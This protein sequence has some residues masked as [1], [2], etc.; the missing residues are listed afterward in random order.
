MANQ[1]DSESFFSELSPGPRAEPNRPVKPRKTGF[2]WRQVIAIDNSQIL[3]ENGEVFPYSELPKLLQTQPSSILVANHFGPIMQFLIREFADNDLWQFRASPIERD[4]YQPNRAGRKAVMKD[5]VIGYLGFRG[6]NKQKGHYHFPLSPQTFVLKGIS[7]LR[8]NAP[9]E[10]STISKLMGWGKEVRDFLQANDL[11]LSPTSGGIAAQFLKDKRFYPNDRRKVPRHTNAKARNHLPGNYYKLYA[12]EG[13]VYRN[14]KAIY[15]AAYLD[16]ISAH[17]TAAKQISFPCANTLR[18]RGRHS[19]LK[20]RPYAKAGTEKYNELIS[21]YGLFYLAIE[22]PRFFPGDFPLP[23]CNKGQGYQ[24]GYF[25]SNEIPYLKGLG[26]RI[27]HIIACW[28]SPDRDY[29][30]NKYAEWAS[31][32]VDKSSSVAKPWLK[33]TLLSTYGVLAAKPKVMEFGY[34]QAKNGEAKQY[35]CGSGFI[36]VIAKASTKPREPLMS[37]VI[38]RG[39]VEAETRLRSL[40]MARELTQEGH[41]ILAI[42]ADSVFVEGSKQLPLLKPPWRL[43]EFLTQ[44]TFR[45][46]THFTSAQI[47]KTPGVPCSGRD[48]SRLPARP[49]RRRE[50]ATKN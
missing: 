12:A 13:G 49:N 21:E 27:R 15:T 30:L 16:Q 20:D 31:A 3:L 5:C 41:T 6:K 19:S 4:A 46:A 42:Y 44:L 34:A 37:N 38:H 32:E 48:S 10:N 33:P 50:A 11:R 45:S 25:Y 36:D 9:D 17:H 14:Q 43:Q 29:G 47:S 1:A 40:E 23:E 8:R 2:I 7:E 24:R 26:V 18:R 22:I 39:M 35:A 28:T